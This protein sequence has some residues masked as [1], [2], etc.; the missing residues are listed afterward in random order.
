MYYNYTLSINGVPE[1]HADKEHDYLTDVITEKSLNFLKRHTRLNKSI[2][3]F[4]MLSPPACHSPFT[5]ANKY[6][7]RFSGIKAPRTP[8]FGKHSPVSYV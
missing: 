4:M 2:P 7:S 6:K 3:F 5:P 1:Y 8:S